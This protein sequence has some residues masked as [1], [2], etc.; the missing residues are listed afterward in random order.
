M[1]EDDEEVHCPHFCEKVLWAVKPEVLGVPVLC[2]VFLGE[3]ARSVVDAEF[4]GAC[5]WIG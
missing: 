4:V 5:A 1:L 3:D 2:G